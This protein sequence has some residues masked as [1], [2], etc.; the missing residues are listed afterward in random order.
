M[1]SGLV[2][3]IEEP[4]DSVLIIT[5]GLGYKVTETRMDILNKDIVSKLAKASPNGI[6]IEKKV[7]QCETWFFD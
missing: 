3:E 4:T 6:I 7:S 1:E 2:T 5:V